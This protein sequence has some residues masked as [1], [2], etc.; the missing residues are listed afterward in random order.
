MLPS[1]YSIYIINVKIY[2]YRIQVKLRNIASATMIILSVLLSLG[3]QVS[4]LRTSFTLFGFLLSSKPFSV[5]SVGNNARKENEGI[6]NIKS[7]WR[8]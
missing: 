1:K 5:V 2:I 6:T 3:S 7:I 4:I 8:K